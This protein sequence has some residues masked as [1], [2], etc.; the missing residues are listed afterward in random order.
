[1]CLGIDITVWYIFGTKKENV[2]AQKNWGSSGLVWTC[3]RNVS[4]STPQTEVHWVQND[5]LRAT[6]VNGQRM[7][8]RLHEGGLRAQRPVVGPVLTVQHRG[9]PLAF[10]RE[11]PK[12][13]LHHWCPVFF[14]DESR[15][16]SKHL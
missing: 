13:Q 7:G 11:H 12:W 9:A 10:A 16:H 2:N 14:T 15:F 4:G 8:N 6:G 5:L 1:M 3:V